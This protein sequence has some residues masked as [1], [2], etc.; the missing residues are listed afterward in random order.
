MWLLLR[1]VGAVSSC[2]MPT[3]LWCAETCIVRLHYKPL[4]SLEKRLSFSSAF[5]AGLIMPHNLCRSWLTVQCCRYC[6]LLAKLKRDPRAP[7]TVCWFLVITWPGCLITTVVGRT[8]AGSYLCIRCHSCS[9][10]ACLISTSQVTVAAAY[11]LIC[12]YVGK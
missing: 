1:L 12:P 6:T 4:I 9:R 10:V 11:T 7:G 5:H 8:A 2:V 3:D